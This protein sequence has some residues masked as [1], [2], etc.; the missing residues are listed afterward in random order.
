MMIADWA[1]P[2]PPSVLVLAAQWSL[3]IYLGLG[4]RFSALAGWRRL[5]PY[6]LAG[7]LAIVAF[8]LVLAYIFSLL[9]PISMATAFLSLSP[10]GMTEMG[11]TASV[12]HAD[13]S[14]VV[15]YQMFRILFILFIVPYA[16]RRLFRVPKGTGVEG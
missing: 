1:P 7:G 5:L 12:V 3:G 2:H 13:V 9:H 16:L 6:S 4:I 8:C 15:A 11:V 14:M 10:G